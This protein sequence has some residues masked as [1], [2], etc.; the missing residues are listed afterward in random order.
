M[1]TYLERSQRLLA[2]SRAY[3]FAQDTER[4]AKRARALAQRELLDADKALTEPQRARF[5][6]AHP[7]ETN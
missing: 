6:A 1:T 7:I 4:A 5:E 2:A 3:Q